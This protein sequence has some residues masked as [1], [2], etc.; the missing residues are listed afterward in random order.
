[1]KDLGC[2][3]TQRDDLVSGDHMLIEVIGS[4]VIDLLAFDRRKVSGQPIIVVLFPSVEGMI[5]ASSTL[6][7]DSEKNLPNRLGRCHGIAMRAMKAGWWMIKSASNSRD[8]LANDGIDRS[9]FC[10]LTSQPIIP[11]LGPLRLITFGSF[12][13]TSLQ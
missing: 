3:V 9:I 7:P 10:I 11:E 8:H 6:H 5:M 12:R 1:M 2:L 13:R 4:L